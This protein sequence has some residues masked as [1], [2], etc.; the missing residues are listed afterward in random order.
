MGWPARKLSERLRL[1]SE[2]RSQPLRRLSDAERTS[3]ARGLLGGPLAQAKAFTRTD[4]VR[5]GAPLLYGA[6][7][8][9]LDRLVDAVVASPEAVAL[10]GRAG[11]RSRA[12]VAASVL[13][14]ELAVEDVAGR[15]AGAGDRASVEHSVAV[16]AKEA[17]LGRPLTAGQRRAVVAVC[18][19]GRG[20]EMV[21]GVASSGKTTALDV[22]RAA[23]EAEGHRVLGTAVSGQATRALAEGAGVESRTVASLVWRLEHGSLRLDRRSVVLIDEA[24][25]FAMVARLPRGSMRVGP[26]QRRTGWP[27]RLVPSRWPRPRTGRQAERV[28]ID[29]IGMEQAYVDEVVRLVSRNREGIEFVAHTVEGAPPRTSLAVL[30]RVPSHTQCL[31]GVR[32]EIWAESN[33]ESAPEAVQFAGY[34]WDRIVE[35]ATAVPIELPE[36]CRPDKAGVTWVNL[37]PDA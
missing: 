17:A 12:W 33:W 10:V 15:L 35:L 20:L 32:D 37:W 23:F 21:V 30:F 29:P 8:G 5:H 27:Y 16:A 6:D 3:L 9:E 11:A 31:Y 14:A 26:A 4:V 28:T 24:G 18:G 19:S 13:A 7:P 22:V 2:A 1:V 36:E 34:T 25:W